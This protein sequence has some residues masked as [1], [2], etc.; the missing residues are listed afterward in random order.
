MNRFSFE[1]R[2]ARAEEL[3]AIYPF[4]KEI[5]LFYRQILMFQ[6]SVR[7]GEHAVMVPPL[8]TLVEETG[9]P[10]LVQASRDLCSKGIDYWTRFLDDFWRSRRSEIDTEAFFAKVIL[11]PHAELQ[12]KQ[13]PDAGPLCPICGGK[14]VASV[15]RPEGHGAKRSLLCAMCSTEWSFPR[16]MCPACGE[17]SFEKLPVHKADEFA[18]MRVDC[19]D[20]CRSYI[21][22]VDL[23]TNGLAVPQVDEIATIPLDLWARQQGYV[24]LELNLFGL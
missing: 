23:A 6:S 4:A 7:P 16:V 13:T 3:A 22:T 21:K 9:T 12:T 5:L 14:P 20:T 19:C 15:L 11:Q 17:Q 10:Q 2:I 18:H 8:L 1:R 24:K